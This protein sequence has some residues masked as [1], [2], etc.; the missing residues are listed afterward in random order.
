MK[1]TSMK[2]I[3][4]IILTALLLIGAAS[5]QSTV[6]AADQPAAKRE[7]AERI[8]QRLEEI[9]KELS[10]TDAQKDQIKPIIHS[11]FE[12]IKALHADTSLTKEQKLEK[13]KSIRNETMS[14]LKPILTAEQLQKWQEVCKKILENAAQ[15]RQGK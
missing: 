3:N 14:Q 10:L 2:I 7:R 12:Q 1:G 8:H 4:R 9:A 15:R 5:L 6:R 13:R 11:A